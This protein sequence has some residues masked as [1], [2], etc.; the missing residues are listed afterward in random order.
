MFQRKHFKFTSGKTNTPGG[1]IWF[2]S[3]YQNTRKNWKTRNQLIQKISI[4]ILRATNTRIYWQRRIIPKI[5]NI[6]PVNS[7]KSAIF[8]GEKF[9]NDSFSI[10]NIILRITL[11]VPTK[12]ASAEKSF[13]KLINNYLRDTMSR[14]TTELYATLSIE[15]NIVKTITRDMNYKQHCRWKGA[16]KNV[17][18]TRYKRLSFY[19]FPNLRR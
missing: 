11:T 1:N 12:S 5:R 6:V 7:E 4:P 2:S 15:R 19:L 14:L 9:L 18:Y 17:Q 13:S 10:T 3:S 16:N 8:F